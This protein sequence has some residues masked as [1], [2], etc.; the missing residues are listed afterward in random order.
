MAVF[1]EKIVGSRDGCC[2]I[3]SWQKYFV[4]GT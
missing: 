1:E 4:T 3:F 2:H